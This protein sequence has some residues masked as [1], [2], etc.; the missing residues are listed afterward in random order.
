MTI[1][2]LGSIGELIAAVATVATLVYL[3]AQIRQNSRQINHN[4]NSVLGSVELETTRLHSDWLL[5]VAQSSELSRLWRLGLSEPAD[6]TEDEEIQFAMLIGS[7][8]YGIEGPFRQH[9]RG[10]LSEDSWAPMEELIARYM[11]SPAVLAWWARREV[12]FSRS[13]S[14][15]VDSKIPE[16]PV[17]STTGSI[18][19]GPTA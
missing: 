15:Y 7:A 19:S 10:L 1:Q 18:W 12:P 13:F 2:D 3:A 16:D 8:F 4:T 14:E 9:K 5:S 17:E 6:L 11:R